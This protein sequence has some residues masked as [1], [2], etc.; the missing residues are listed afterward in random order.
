MNTK[1]TSTVRRHHTGTARRHHT[2]LGVTALIGLVGAGC[3]SEDL[4]ERA[5]EEG[6]ERESGDDVDIDLDD[7]N[8][9]I[10][11]EDGVVEMNTDGDGN[12]SIEG[13]GVDGDFS[14]DSEDGVTVI[15]SEDGD[16]VVSQGGGEV[17]DDFPGSVPLPDGF[18]P[19]FTQS[20][21]T[22]DGG[23][24][25]LAGPIDMSAAD[26]AD[27]YFA[28]LESAGFARQAVTETPD[29]IIFGFDNGEYSVNGVA[30]EDGSGA[31]YFNLTVAES[32]L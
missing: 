10:E 4:A 16:T 22:S 31:T 24:W 32:Q 5:I 27:S 23:G 8:V 19:E 14:I 30:G 29:T 28:A 6:I 11:T 7:G 2:I 20:M 21:S 13:E 9:R 26:L 12:V 15:E 17:P 1:R 3:S 25:V 18:E